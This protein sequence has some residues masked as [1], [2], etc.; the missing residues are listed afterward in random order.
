MK[1]GVPV[2]AFLVEEL[3]DGVDM[4]EVDDSKDELGF[5][6]GDAFAIR[7]QF[8]AFVVDILFELGIRAR[9]TNSKGL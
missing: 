4:D 9:V 7:E 5:A 1:V 3:C 6:S 8:A 2:V